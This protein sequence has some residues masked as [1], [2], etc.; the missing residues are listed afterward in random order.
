M[1]QGDSLSIA[2]RYGHHRYY[3]VFMIIEN[4]FKR[5]DLGL[6]SSSLQVMNARTVQALGIEKSLVAM[7]ASWVEHL[8]ME[9]WNGREL[10][11]WS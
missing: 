5:F 3:H 6:Y 10:G 7:Y 1:I 11:L 9:W 2:P 4:L 8:A